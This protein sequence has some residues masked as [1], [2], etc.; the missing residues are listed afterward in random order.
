MFEIG[1]RRRAQLK[2]FV[3]LARTR[4]SRCV[5]I[6]YLT[7]RFDIYE[8][9]GA[10][11]ECQQRTLSLAELGDVKIKSNRSFHFVTP[12]FKEKR[13]VLVYMACSI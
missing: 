2:T 5:K 3:C 6:S 1:V 8:M 12:H 4:E 9:I 7:N 11:T 13:F 10:L